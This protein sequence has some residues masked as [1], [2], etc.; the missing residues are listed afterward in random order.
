MVSW[1][2]PSQHSV[3]LFKVS[4]LYFSL[5][6]RH[7]YFRRLNQKKKKRK[8]GGTAGISG[9]SSRAHSLPRHSSARTLPT[10]PFLLFRTLCPHRNFSSFYDSYTLSLY[11]NSLVAF[12]CLTLRTL[13]SP[14]STPITT[15]FWCINSLPCH[16]LSPSLPSASSSDAAST[17]SFPL[18][19][20]L[21]SRRAF[22][23][24]LFEPLLE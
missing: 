4:C 9:S 8:W 18:L 19:W 15:I 21:P 24:R 14:P 7:C 20:I 10:S 16:N 5:L 1:H 23:C 22:C 6:L 3:L 11:F 12:F 2:S 17:H 13:F